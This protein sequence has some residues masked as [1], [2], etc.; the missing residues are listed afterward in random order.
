MIPLTMVVLEELGRGPSLMA[1]AERDYPVETFVSNPPWY[2][3]KNSMLGISGGQAAG[4]HKS[5]TP[6]SL[7]SGE[8]SDLSGFSGLEAA[9]VELQ[10]RS[11]CQ[12]LEAIHLA[13]TR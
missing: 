4:R 7:L 11:I 1:L 13:Q 8:T 5:G 6:E 2:S 3:A 9:G 10:Q 12:H